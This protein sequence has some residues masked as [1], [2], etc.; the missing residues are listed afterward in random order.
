M[1]I[2]G[3]Y[4]V[5]AEFTSDTD[6]QLGG[7]LNLPP[8]KATFESSGKIQY[9]QTEVSANSCTLHGSLG[10]V[11][12]LTGYRFTLEERKALWDQAKMLGASDIDGWYISKA[13]DL[14][15]QYWNKQNPTNQ[16]VSFRIDVGSPQWNAV[17]EKGYSI[18][19]G[20]QGNGSYNADEKTGVLDETSFGTS[21]YAH[22]I[23]MKDKDELIYNEDIDNYYPI[24]TTNIYEVPKNNIQA[25]VNNNVYFKSAYVFCFTQDYNQTQ[26]MAN[27]SPWATV[28]VQKA[29]AKGLP[30]NGPQE[31]MTNAELEADL[32]KLGIFITMTGNMSR[33]RWEV[34]LDR[35]H[36]LT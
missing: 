14:V 21:T 16:L 10:A 7:A 19:V 4:G 1:Q 6:F 27:V 32:V 31:Q 33:E 34:A 36:A 17:I 8:A 12:D 30:I 3:F 18:V 15:R 9:N 20:Y 25:L 2:D 29:L 24:Y 22:C 11:S 13:V 26:I 5:K 35:L 23:R 28:S